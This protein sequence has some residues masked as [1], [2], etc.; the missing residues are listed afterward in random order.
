MIYTVKIPEG[1][2]KDWDKYGYVDFLCLDGVYRIF[3]NSPEKL[4][5]VFT[6]KTING[7]GKSLRGNARKMACEAVIKILESGEKSISFMA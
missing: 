1:N 2:E 6:Q 4:H 5:T 7:K 3:K